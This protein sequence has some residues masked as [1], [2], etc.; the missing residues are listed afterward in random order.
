MFSKLTLFKKPK[1]FFRVSF[2]EKLNFFF[3][4]LSD[5]G[6]AIGKTVRTALP[7]VK[8]TLNFTVFDAFAADFSDLSAKNEQNRIIRG[9][10]NKK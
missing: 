8:T 3:F 9:D 6:F 10:L 1:S 2:F 4:F 5:P 7:I